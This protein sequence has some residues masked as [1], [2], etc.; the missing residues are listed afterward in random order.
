[1]KKYLFLILALI[2][3]LVIISPAYAQPEGLRLSISRD[4]GYG[5]FGN[6][7]Q[8]LFSMIVT[9]PSD[10]SRVEF[11]IDETKIGEL[12]APPYR[13][14][15][16]TDNYEL[17]EHTLYAVG[18]TVD[19]KKVQSNNA[20]LNFVPPQSVGKFNIPVL[21]IVVIAI[22]GSALIPLL[23]NRGKPINLPPGT[24]RNYG[25]GG[26]GICPRC[27]RPFALPLFSMNLLFSKLAR[28]PYCG[29]WGAVKIQSLPR[30]REAERAELL[31]VIDQKPN[32]D[33]TDEENLRKE[34]DDSRYQ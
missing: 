15:F 16:N 21:G 22:L 29:R 34:L 8:G 6:D 13:F 33:A 1:M 20:I 4:W 12:S 9:G 27:Q 24:E 19:G 23:I 14:Q 2:S 28:C 17:G 26:G 5:G 25:V 7:V 31:K 11:Y 10:L 18:Y 30:L 3:I 32:S